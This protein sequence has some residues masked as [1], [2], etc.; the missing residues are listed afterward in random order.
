MMHCMDYSNCFSLQR[1]DFLRLF[2]CG[3]AAL[4][5]AQAAIS[6]RQPGNSETVKRP[7]IPSQITDI[8]IHQPV[9]LLRILTNTG[10]EGWSLGVSE[11]T[12][13]LVQSQYRS[14]LIGRDPLVRERL[15]QEFVRLDQFHQRIPPVRAYLDAALWDLGGKAVGLPVY[16]LIG[17]FRSRVP[18]YRTG[19]NVPGIGAAVEE[20]LQARAEGFLGYKDQCRFSVKG[21]LDLA[22]ALREAVGPDFYLMHDGGQR[23]DHA[24]AL[25]VGRALQSLA[26][27]WFEEPLRDADTLGL[28]QLSEALDIP[29]AAGQKMP[30]A[31]YAT[32]QLLALQAV[33]IIG[34]SVPLQGGI[35]DVL[36]MARLAEAFIVHC[37]I[38]SSDWMGGFVGAH[39]LGAVKNSAF[40][41]ASNAGAQAGQP[42]I[43]NPLA[44]EKGYL[45]VPQG[46]G[47]G[48]D[49]DWRE[50]EKQT[51]HVI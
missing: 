48:I 51:T 8:K 50:V 5:L 18:A 23:Y 12:A 40:F 2:P 33:D 29:I 49:L 21:T 19:K 7:A 20:A 22:K 31:L 44:V 43:K 32:S 11:D 25:Q 39:L 36:K 45:A 26:Y 46:P 14:A 6:Q 4:S 27:Y 38:R 9:G 34:A 17:G 3:T 1:R 35:T 42:L 24:E 16:R 30:D 47:L 15:W 13:R 41:D 28:K 37:E 10:V